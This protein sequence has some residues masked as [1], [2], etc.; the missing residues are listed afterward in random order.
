MKRYLPC[1]IFACAFFCLLVNKGAV[2]AQSA[3]KTPDKAAIALAENASV[4]LEKHC[5]R[6]HGNNPTAGFAL[7]DH[8]SMLAKGQI[9]PNDA[10]GSRVYVRV[11][12]DAGDPMPPLSEHDTLPDAEKKALK[13]WIEAGAPAGVAAPAGPAR[14]LVTEESVLNLIAADIDAAEERDRPFLR[15][16]T[17]TDLLNAGVNDAQAES[18]RTG[19]A[20]L[21]NSL[22]WQRRIEIPQALDPAKSV[23]RIDLRKYTWTEATWKSM[24]GEYPYGVLSQLPVAKKVCAG[25]KCALPYVRADWFVARGSVPPLYNV[26]LDLPQTAS[27]LEQRLLVDVDKDLRNE[28]AIRAGF[29][30]SGVSQHNRIVERH[31]SSYGAYWKSHD[32]S[33]STGRQNIFQNPLG[34]EPAGGEI[35][36]SLPNGLQGFMLVKGNGQRIDDGPISIVSNK[37]NNTDP[38]VHNGLTC[39][40]CHVQGMKRFSDQVRNVVEQADPSAVNYDRNKALALYVSKQKQDVLVN[41]DIARFVQAVRAVGSQVADKEPLVK[42]STDFQASLSLEQAAAEVGVSS[43]DFAAKI[44]QKS[45]LGQLIGVLG[46]PG[47][48]IQRDA[49]EESFGAIVQ[50]MALGECLPY[51]APARRNP[52]LAGNGGIA[53]APNGGVALPAFEKQ[54]DRV[55]TLPPGKAVSVHLDLRETG[56][57]HLTLVRGA[58]LEVSGSLEAGSIPMVISLQIRAAATNVP[59]TKDWKIAWNSAAE[60][61]DVVHMFVQRIEA[62]RSIR[63]G[64][65]IVDLVEKAPSTLAWDVHAA[66]PEGAIGILISSDALTAPAYQFTLD[67]KPIDIVVDAAGHGTLSAARLPPG[68]HMLACRAVTKEGNETPLNGLLLHISPAINLLPF[69]SDTIDLTQVQDISSVPIHIQADGRVAPTAAQ[70]FVDGKSVARSEQSPFTDASFNPDKLTSGQHVMTAQVTGSDGKE[71]ASVP[72]GFRIMRAPRVEMTSWIA[73]TQLNARE[74]SANIA[75]AQRLL[76]PPRVGFGF[77]GGGFEG[78]IAAALP[79]LVSLAQ[80]AVRFVP[81]AS[82]SEQ[83]RKS[84]A[85]AA[86]EAAR[87]YLDLKE[88]C[89]LYQPARGGFGGSSQSQ[90]SL[91]AAGKALSELVHAQGVISGAATRVG[92]TY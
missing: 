19:L 30:Q 76:K 68:D 71:Y 79:H 39:M 55:E 4:I 42:L 50:E 32:F 11:A 58:V 75:L 40:S 10:A 84:L 47:G 51:T 80:S 7:R 82:I 20:K 41:E 18:F 57:R 31:E 70:F 29:N 64:E 86:G 59:T 62:T 72:V 81:P 21:L 6:C 65:I 8:K 87:G 38:V 5:A 24:L 61:R 37:E 52:T 13:S 67:D 27:A 83:D 36:F 92:A 43:S 2:R 16:F 45:K 74:L 85:D 22:S 77:G 25:T 3:G 54:P 89:R 35:I 91:T 73:A 69:P 1:R 9:K 12:L 53:G 15:Y 33:S 90:P 88:A 34:F 28:T 49:W 66:L 46:T 44:H 26:L 78:E 17:L 14:H 48:Q 63:I 60:P 23:L 56:P